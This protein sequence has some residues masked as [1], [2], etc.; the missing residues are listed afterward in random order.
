[1]ENYCVYVDNTQIAFVHM[2]HKNG[3]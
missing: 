1:M 2:R 3:K